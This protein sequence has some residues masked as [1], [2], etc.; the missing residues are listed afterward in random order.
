MAKHDTFALMML[1]HAMTR[2]LCA[3]ICECAGRSGRECYYVTRDRT[4]RCWGPQGRGDHQQLGL[5]LHIILGV[6]CVDSPDIIRR[7]QARR[8]FP[9][10]S[11]F[12]E[13]ESFLRRLGGSILEGGARCCPQRLQVVSLHSITMAA[14]KNGS[15]EKDSGGGTVRK[16]V[17]PHR[18]ELS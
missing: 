8:T 4:G 11:G 1:E 2:G 16:E 14:P 6:L 12:F 13:E 15:T 18:W 17:G 3:R 10:W 9:L 5:E 7:L